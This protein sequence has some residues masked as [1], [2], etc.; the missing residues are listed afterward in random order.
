MSSTEGNIRCLPSRCQHLLP[1]LRVAGAPCQAP[2]G[3]PVVTGAATWSAK[4]GGCGA[5][6]IQGSECVLRQP[7]AVV[8]VAF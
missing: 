6:F 2:A 5:Q 7:C 1:W 8:T 3:H 4:R